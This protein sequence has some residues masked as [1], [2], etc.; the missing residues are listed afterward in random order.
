MSHKYDHCVSNIIKLSSFFMA[1]GLSVVLMLF[2][3]AMLFR[4]LGDNERT[5]Y[6]TLLSSIVSIWL[7]S[8]SSLVNIR[9]TINTNS[10]RVSHDSDVED[11]QCEN[12]NDEDNQRGRRDESEESENEEGLRLDVINTA[13]TIAESVKKKR[14]MIAEHKDEE[15]NVTDSS[16]DEDYVPTT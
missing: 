16:D 7:P 5:V 11:N 14:R 8:P 9:Q 10:A 15:N 3:C 13:E 6:V 2:C 12:E 4:K 1:A